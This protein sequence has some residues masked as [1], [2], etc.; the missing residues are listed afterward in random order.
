MAI[1]YSYPLNDNIKPLDELVGTT[2]QSINGQLK[3]VTRNFLIQDLAEFFIVDGGLQKTITLTT[4]GTSGEATLNQV[5]G[6]LNI[7]QY[8]GGSGSSI[9]LSPIGSSSNEN[10][11]TIT[12]S[13]LNLQPAS[14]SFGG[15]IT[16][17]AQT[18][19]G[20]KTFTSTTYINNNQQE[21]NALELNIN[22]EYTNG[23]IVNS[24]SDYTSCISIGVGSVFN[25]NITP[26]QIFDEYGDV[27][28]VDRSGS[29]NSNIIN[30]TQFIKIGGAPSEIL[31]ADGNVITAGTNITIVDGVISAIGGSSGGGSTVNYYLNG[32]TSQ[33]TFGGTTYYEFSRTAILGTGAD[34]TRNTNGYIASFITN[35]A[36]PSSLLIPGG[37]WNLEFYFSSSSAGGSPSFYTELYKYDGTTFTLIASDSATPE[38]IT[39]GTT[40]DAYYTALAVP[41]TVLTINDR[42]AIRVY[43][44]TSGRTITLHTQ[45]GHLC[46]VITTF[47]SGLTTLNGLQGQVQNFSVGTT[48]TDF[49]IS[50]SGS[51]HTFNLPNASATARGVVTIGPQT[52]AGAKTF[53]GAISASNLSGTNTGNQNLQQVTSL[54]GLSTTPIYINAYNES[55]PGVA[56]YVVSDDVTGSSI[57]ADVTGSSTGVVISGPEAVVI[58]DSNY[59][60]TII[61]AGSAAFVTYIQNGDAALFNLG[62]YARGLVINSGTSSI[63]NPIEI[64]KEDET[65]LTVNQEGELSI[66]KIPGGLSTEYLM[67]D[68]STSGEGSPQQSLSGTGMT[69]TGGSLPTGTNTHFYRWSQAGNLVTLRINLQFGTAGTCSGI[70][71]PFANMP[72]IPQVPQHPSIY[73]AALDMITYGS[74]NLSSNKL[75]GTFSVGNGASGIRIKTVGTP[76]TYEVVVGRASNA[77]SNGWIHI[78]Y[79][80]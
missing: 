34:F 17:G 45:N 63:G 80:I 65:K 56:L 79:Y 58:Y 41:E 71:I 55:E 36:D 14:A 78:Q 12:G 53:T 74:G 70:A 16:T 20:S 39:N 23:I 61:D 62:T 9:T 60:V 3:T 72:D 77:Y 18:I 19:S 67:A 64:V 42:L 8:S 46:E 32:G 50:S 4:N 24:N 15:V 47:T 2:E 38:G 54:G 49:A 59:G 43:V 25:T 69:A 33:G 1:I 22:A 68:G 37:N 29:I 13:V 57:G 30:A 26:L 48:G 27:F 73:N 10:G 31:A 28:T 7:P 40:I 51:T 52:F 5:T 75:I 35:V 76:N 21:T 11:A 66:V 44:N 6:V